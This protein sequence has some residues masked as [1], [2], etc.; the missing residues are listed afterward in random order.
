MGRPTTKVHKKDD[1]LLVTTGNKRPDGEKS[2]HRQQVKDKVKSGKAGNAQMVPTDSDVKDGADVKVK[3]EK[4]V[5]WSDMTEIVPTNSAV[6]DGTD[7]KV[8]GKIKDKVPAGT[9]S[10]EGVGDSDKSSHGL[11]YEGRKLRRKVG[12][13][14]GERRIAENQSVTVGIG[15][16]AHVVHDKGKR[17]GIRDVSPVTGK[18]SALATH[19]DEAAPPQW[20]KVNLG[21]TVVVNG[22]RQNLLASVPAA[23]VHG[24]GTVQSAYEGID[25]LVDTH[26][27]RYRM[28]LNGKQ[29]LIDAL[30]RDKEGKL[31]K[32]TLVHD[33][34]ASLNVLS[35]KTGRKWGN[36]GDE[37]IQV[38][39]FEG[40]TATGYGGN[41]LEVYMLPEAIL[42]TPGSC[43]IL[44]V[45]AVNGFDDCTDGLDDPGDREPAE[46]FNQQIREQVQFSEEIN[47]QLTKMLGCVPTK[48]LLDKVKNAA[49]ILIDDDI[50][51]GSNVKG[52]NKYDELDKPK[53]T[54]KMGERLKI[55]QRMRN[56]EQ[57]KKIYP[58]CSE[59]RLNNM[60]RDGIITNGVLLSPHALRDEADEI[61][62]GKK[63]K[64]KRADNRK[65]GAKKLPALSPFMLT[66]TD[67]I[68]LNGQCD[69]NRG[70]YEYVIVFMCAK[71]GYVKVYPMVSKGDV[72]DAW[73]QFKRWLRVN[74]V[75]TMAKLGV[76]M[77]V[78]VL[79]SDRGG[80]YT[81]TY[82]LTRSEV[83][84]VLHKDGVLR[85]SPSAGESDKGVGKVERFNWTLVSSTNASLRRGG[86]TNDYAYDSMCAWFPDHYNA[87]PTDANEDGG[88]APAESLGIPFDRSVFV[89]FFCP[90]FV[91]M[92]KFHTSRRGEDENEE[93]EE[94][95]EKHFVERKLRCFIIGYGGGRLSGRDSPGYR[96][97]I[98]GLDGQV[99]MSTNV[100]PTP[101]ME[102]IKSFITGLTLNPLKHEAAL[103]NKHFDVSGKD[104]LTLSRNAD[105]GGDDIE[106]RW[107]ADA[108]PPTSADGVVLD[109]GRAPEDNDDHQDTLAEAEDEEVD[110][111]DTAP[112]ETRAKR[113]DRQTFGAAVGDQSRATLRPHT[114]SKS[115]NDIM[116]AAQAKA[117]RRDAKQKNFRIALK[118]PEVAGKKDKS[119]Q[120]YELQ[121]DKYHG[122]HYRDYLQGRKVPIEYWGPY[123]G[124]HDK[125]V[126][127]GDPQNDVLKGH[128]TRWDDA[129]DVANVTTDIGG[130][131]GNDGDAADKEDDSSQDDNS[132]DDGTDLNRGNGGS[133]SNDSRPT[134]KGNGGSSKG[135]AAE[136]NEGN[137][138][139]STG[140]AAEGDFEDGGDYSQDRGYNHVKLYRLRQYQEQKA[141]FEFACYLKERR[142]AQLKDLEIGVAHQVTDTEPE[143][144]LFAITPDERESDTRDR[145]FAEIV[146][147]VSQEL[148]RHVKT[149]EAFAVFHRAEV[150]VHGMKKPHS[151]KEAMR[152]KEWPLWK[153]AIR[154]EILS[155][156]ANGVFAEVPKAAV[157]S[158]AK[159]FP[160]R[161]VL[162]IKTKDGKIDKFKSRFV[163]RG[164][165]SRKGID[166]FESASH[167]V[168]GKTLRTLYA[169]A[170]VDYARTKKES[171]IPRFADIKTAFLTRR[172]RATDPE[173]Y[174]LFPE[175]SDGLLPDKHGPTCGKLLTNIYG[176]QD[177][178]RMF[179]A[180]LLDF[181]D[182][183]GAEA[184]V[185]DRMCFRWNWNGETMRAAVHVDD[186]IYNGSNDAILDEFYRRMVAWFGACVG[187]TRADFVLGLR[188]DWDLD[189]GTVKLS[190]RAHAE[191]LLKEFGYDPATI[192]T[193][194][195]PFPGNVTISA[196]ENGGTHR[197]VPTSEFD[198]FKFVGFL[199]W[200]AIST[201]VDLA[202]AVG[203]LG[204]YSSKPLLQHVQ[205]AKHVMRY[206]GGTMDV[207]LTYHGSKEDLQACEGYDMT[208]RLLFY[209]DADHG[210]C[211]DTGR[212]TSCVIGM[213]N[214]AAVIWSSRR[215]RVNTTSTAHSEMIALASGVMEI[216]WARDLLQELGFPQGTVRVL[217]DNS[218]TLSQS[219]G[220]Y[221]SSKSDHYRR[222]QFYVEDAVNQGKVWI[223]KCMTTDMLA[224]LGTKQVWPSKQFVYLR[225]RAMGTTLGVPL[226]N[227]VK[228]ILAGRR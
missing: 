125:L 155:L 184:L 109:T 9:G 164:D 202:G 203:V 223:D 111:D 15:S 48:E 215:Q 123:T 53:L 12:L 68:D 27:R 162:D 174:A 216:E 151:V 126:L 131:K 214:G 144:I 94:T 50:Y 61:G 16:A 43:D 194:K 92:P 60:V 112:E 130:S 8:K 66:L 113:T 108:P 127:S 181:M 36:A 82:G 138:G 219:S 226:S 84:E 70:G 52:G 56:M 86:A 182:S 195:T 189:K 77:K 101:E 38:G 105:P 211:L 147:Q 205:L 18:G 90:A 190:Q 197:R 220:D 4:K 102:V 137:G 148:G 97:V 124:Q 59:T 46:D 154:K 187:N 224:D 49:T 171:Y 76:P 35:T 75:H 1:N 140:T 5:R 178:S 156:I 167:Q 192:T 166:Y 172:R 165:L 117:W 227:T 173:L 17:T 122:G 69:G 121:Y 149:W 221:K 51:T 13:S 208:N 71:Y 207:G 180:E 198:Y 143:G 196:E 57:A 41:D 170:A 42:A 47:T 188:V 119:R 114:K 163:L 150:W 199:N 73:T 24:L 65:P 118:H 217:E 95:N 145:F 37:I 153:D 25:Y 67:V 26:G 206:V 40:S 98:P 135:T 91:R 115:K 193:S 176:S 183:I 89:P 55:V 23:K 168:R 11:T 104:A 74:S 28:R 191:K 83:D 22:T 21:R 228:D 159:I 134:D 29:M 64:T 132:R 136:G 157:P 96:V 201:R 10:S 179:E 110:R 81:T 106:P 107:P 142:V 58:H 128:L 80:E 14:D 200:L 141:D 186:C 160:G 222:T 93:A 20:V 225:D 177:G 210:A 99:Y 169:M 175:W 85:W 204:R 44:N 152:M 31:R 161:L 39:G 33:S 87:C 120:R 54:R 129:S 34:G 133:S 213:M 79:V 212:S 7:D 88:K 146:N 116:T 218:A 185:T 32:T 100:T 139:S 63:E 6:N 45:A 19:D 78:L 158:T 209:C 30:I 3:D 2:R 103:I 62:R 72:L